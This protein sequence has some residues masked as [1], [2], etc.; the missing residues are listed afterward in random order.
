MQGTELDDVEPVWRDNVRAAL[1]QV[2][3]LVGCDLGHGSEDMRGVC[4]NE[5]HSARD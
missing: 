5:S 3:G 1:E 4:L 2:L